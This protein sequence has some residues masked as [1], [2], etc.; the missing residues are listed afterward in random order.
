MKQKLFAVFFLHKRFVF[1]YNGIVPCFYM[2]IFEKKIN[3]EKNSD[4]GDIE[5]RIV[6]LN[7][8]VEKHV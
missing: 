1:W 6:S 8:R 5:S 2:N 7:N 3:S 4:T